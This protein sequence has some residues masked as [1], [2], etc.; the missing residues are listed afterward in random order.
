MEMWW[1]V[2]NYQCVFLDHTK[3][4]TEEVNMGVKDRF[5]K[6]GVFSK[7]HLCLAIDG[8][9]YDCSDD[10]EYYEQK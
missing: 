4:E 2:F 5:H 1:M 7:K 6:P 9:V 10:C 8:W 3:M